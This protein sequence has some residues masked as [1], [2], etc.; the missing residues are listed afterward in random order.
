MPTTQFKNWPKTRTDISPKKTNTWPTAL[1]MMLNIAV[2]R[3][4][5]IKPTMRYHLTPVRMAIIKKS[6]NNKCWRGC[7]KKGTLLHC[8]WECNLVYPL[9]KTVWRFLEKLNIE[10][11]Y[12]PAILLLG[13]HLEKNYNSKRYM[14]PSVHCNTIDN[15]QDME[16][17]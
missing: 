1:V 5:P 2:I 16:A 4:M 13:I 15:S 17:T 3:E 11:Q 6:T 12:D 7:G 9:W 14:H 10:L 8:W